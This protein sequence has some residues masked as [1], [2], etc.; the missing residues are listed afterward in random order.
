MVFKSLIKT[1]KKVRFFDGRAFVRVDGGVEQWLI[2]QKVTVNRLVSQPRIALYV[3]LK[4][5]ILRGFSPRPFAPQAI[6]VLKIGRFGNSFQQVAKA[7]RLAERSQIKKLV[8]E[9]TPWLIDSFRSAT[10]VEVDQTGTKSKSLKRV[11]TVIVGRFLWEEELTYE[12]SYLREIEA[13]TELKRHFSF[14]V[15]K[16]D[17]GSEDLVVHLRGGDVYSDDPP[18]DYGQPPLGFYL[19]ILDTH[20]WASVTVIHE[21]DNPV[22]LAALRQH[23]EQ[24]GIAHTF[25]SSSLHEDLSVLLAAQNLVVGN[26]SFA[27]AICEM[28]LQLK[29]VFRLAGTYGVGELPTGAREISVTDTEGAFSRTILNGNWDNTPAQRELM[30]TYPKEKFHL[31]DVS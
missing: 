7:M 29:Q 17:F 3:S 19:A 15:R 25:Q 6:Y 27:R 26:G 13:A 18:H 22:V 1:I 14:P 20:E 4:E 12:G 24:S 5:L 2:T 9:K 16:P 21:D 10:N 30:I 31:G 23:L 8:L 11:D 28:S